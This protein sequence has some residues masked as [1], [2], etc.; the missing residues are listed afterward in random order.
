MDRDQILS[1]REVEGMIADGDSIV[2]F[3]DYV[4]RLNGWLDK[5]PGGSLVIQHMVGRDATDEITA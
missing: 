4:L 5:H 3:Q 2:I 1:Q